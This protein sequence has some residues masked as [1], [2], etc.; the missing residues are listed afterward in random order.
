MRGD[1]EARGRCRGFLFAQPDFS[2]T[3]SMTRRRRAVSNGCFGFRSAALAC[4]RRRSRSR[5][6]RRSASAGTRRGRALAS[7]ASSSV[8][9]WTAKAWWMLRHRAQ[10]ADA[11]VRRRRAVLDAQVRRC[12]YGMSVQPMPTC[13]PPYCSS[14]SKVEPIGGNA[15]RCSQAVGQ[16]VRVDRGLQV[17]R[18]RRVEVV[19]L[20]VVF[21]APDHLDRL[22]DLAATSSAAS[23]T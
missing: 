7:A 12:G 22:A 13:Q 3:S 6:A 18:G 20:Q 15:V 21:A 23:A 8:K 19:E 5:A 14:A 1:A 9:L 16:P 10:P 17:L 4:P 2:A 11:D